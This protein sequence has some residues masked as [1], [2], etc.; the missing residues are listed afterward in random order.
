MIRT[1]NVSLHNNNN[2]QYS[3]C[4][5]IWCFYS[6]I[7]TSLFAVVIRWKEL[8]KQPIPDK[9]HHPGGYS[10]EPLTYYSSKAVDRFENVS[11]LEM[12][13]EQEESK[14]I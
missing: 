11:L 8:Y 13:E 2:Q 14:E 3:S 10:E 7:Q 1:Y 4:A 6:V 5:A 9:I 12:P